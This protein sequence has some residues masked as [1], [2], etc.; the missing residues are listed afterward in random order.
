MYEYII[1]MEKKS[2]SMTIEHMGEDKPRPLNPLPLQTATG[3]L[4][5]SPQQP[6]PETPPQADQPHEDGDGTWDQPDIRTYQGSADNKR[7]QY[8]V[9]GATTTSQRGSSTNTDGTASSQRGYNTAGTTSSQGAYNRDGSGGYPASG[10]PPGR[11]YGPA[12]S[13]STDGN[14]VSRRTFY[15]PSGT[16]IYVPRHRQYDLPYNRATGHRLRHQGRHGRSQRSHYGPDWSYSS[17]QQRTQQRYPT[18]GLSSPSSGQAV[19]GPNTNGGSPSLHY[20]A[21]PTYNY[22]YPA[23]GQNP[24]GQG[25]PHVGQGQPLVGQVQPHV[26]SSSTYNQRAGSTAHRAP[27]NIN[28]AAPGPLNDQI[29]LS[30][31]DSGSRQISNLDSGSD[32]SW[33]ISGFTECT[34]TCGGGKSVFSE[35]LTIAT[36]WLT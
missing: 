19:V 2:G 23:P 31:P 6:S 7:F 12:G 10:G 30:F 27:Y 28:S 14:S 9:A 35:I 25:Q 8:Q 26:Y 34:L 33:R 20:Q 17:L 22:A 11:P 1:P 29:A 15:R 13:P 16:D 5:P 3:D 18:N 36:A 32:Y 4:S 24:S 21:G